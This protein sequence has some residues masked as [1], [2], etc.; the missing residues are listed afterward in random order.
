[1]DSK[2]GVQSKRKCGI[3][4]SCVCIV[5]FPGV[6]RIVMNR[7]CCGEDDLWLCCMPQ[8]DRE[9]VREREGGWGGG[10]G[11]RGMEGVGEG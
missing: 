8:K 1:M 2:C 9:K 4:E 11:E 5:G 7:D 10:G 6:S 3:H